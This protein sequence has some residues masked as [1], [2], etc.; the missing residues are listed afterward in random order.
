MVLESVIGLTDQLAVERFSP[1]PD[2]S[3]ATSR[4]ALRFDRMQRRS[5][6]TISALKR[7]PSCL[8]SQSRSAYRPG[9]L[10]RPELLEK[11]GQSENF[12]LH[13]LCNASNS[14]SNSSPIST[15]Q[16]IQDYYITQYI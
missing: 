14:G 1:T 13:V 16:L 4:I 3:P 6:T 15:T 12:R 7:N 9:A 8:G 5:S 11:P 2:L 10:H